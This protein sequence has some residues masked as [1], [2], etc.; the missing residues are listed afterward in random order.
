VERFRNFGALCGGF[1]K[2]ASSETGVA[3]APQIRQDFFMELAS[4]LFACVRSTR[5]ISESREVLPR[6]A[7]NSSLNNFQMIPLL[8]DSSQASDRIMR[9]NSEKIAAKF[10][11]YLVRPL[12]TLNYVTPA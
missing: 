5:T 12:T 9:N 1:F 3:E 2:Q 4:P 11:T 8:S 10:H 7:L 6:I